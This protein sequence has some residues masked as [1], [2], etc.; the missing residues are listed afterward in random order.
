MTPEDQAAFDALVS[1]H[2]ADPFY[3]YDI[4]H[5]CDSMAKWQVIYR[6]QIGPNAAIAVGHGHTF[7]E[8]A[9]SVR[10]QI[11]GQVVAP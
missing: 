9:T 1:D 6:S 8:A 4:R 10:N 5:V 2:E 11:R 7:A 3:F